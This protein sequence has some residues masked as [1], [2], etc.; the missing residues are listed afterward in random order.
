MPDNIIN[1][2]LDSEAEDAGPLKG[3]ANQTGKWFAFIVLFGSLLTASSLRMRTLGSS[4]SNWAGPGVAV[5]LVLCFPQKYIFFPGDL[6]VGEV[7]RCL[8]PFGVFF[9]PLST[10]NSL[11]PMSIP[12]D[13]RR[14]PR[15]DVLP[16][17]LGISVLGN[18]V[19][20]KRQH[21]RYD[22]CLFSSDRISIAGKENISDKKR[23]ALVAVHKS[24]VLTKSSSICGG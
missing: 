19:V 22:L 13:G 23:C 1:L 16:K 20:G 21:G 7:E 14:L 10:L 4:A 8:Y 18:S 9:R 15:P 2:N 6:P 11:E 24:V 3:E 17:P 5:G 12:S